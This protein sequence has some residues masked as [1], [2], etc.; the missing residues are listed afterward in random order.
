LTPRST[1][2]LNSTEQPTALA[3]CTCVRYR[4]LRRSATHWPSFF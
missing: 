4:V 1:R 2:L 3:S